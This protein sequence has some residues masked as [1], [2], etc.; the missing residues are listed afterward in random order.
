MSENP[1]PVK[2]QFTKTQMILAGLLGVVFII[3]EIFIIISLSRNNDTQ[4]IFEQS[5]SQVTALADLQTQILHLQIETR[6]LMANQ[7][8]P[9]FSQ[10]DAQLA[11][12][13]ESLAKAD[14]L[15]GNDEA[16]A[17][18]LGQVRLNLAE[19]EVI[20]GELKNNPTISQF[21]SAD[22][23]LTNQLNEAE[24]DYITPEY[25]RI[26]ANFNQNINEALQVRQFSQA[27]LLG[28]SLFIFFLVV[29]LLLSFDRVIRTEFA[30][31]FQVVGSLESAV[32]LKTRDL[33]L[34]VEVGH[35]LTQ[36][37][38]LDILLNEAVNLIRT[39]FNLYH[40]QIYLIDGATQQLVLKA[41]T[42]P[43]GAELLRR[44]H[45]LP[46]DFTS[47]NGTAAVNKEPIVVGNTQSNP[48]F[49]PNPLLPAT[50]SESAIPL[51]IGNQVLGVLDLQSEQLN[52]FSP[53]NLP[54]FE[55]VANQLAIAI[56]NANL[57]ST[58]QQ[59][60]AELE[61]LTQR[62]VAENWANFMNAVDRPEQ[63][64]YVYERGQLR[65]T[66]S[67]FIPQPEENLLTTAITLGNQPIGKIELV[68][69]TDQSWT[70]EQIEFANI[71]AQQI[72]QQLENLRLLAEARQYRSQAE[73]AV[74]QLTREGWATYASQHNT[75]GYLY[76]GQQ[77]QEISDSSRPEQPHHPLSI[78]GE[79]I[80]Y[81]T[82]TANES[83]NTEDNELIVR[84]I[85]ERLS[86]HIENLRL[87]Q[88][89]TQALTNA[90]QRSAELALINRIVSTVGSSLDLAQSLQ[91]VTDELAILTGA[92]RSGIAL[93][94]PTGSYLTVVAEHHAPNTPTGLGA[95]IPI[96]GNFTT[97]YVMKHRKTLVI[98]DVQND[99]RTEPIHQLMRTH[100][101]Y[102]L[103][104]IPMIS[105][106][107]VIGTAGIDILRPN[108]EV[109]P[110]Q[111]K[112]AETI[113]YQAT[114]AIENTR[115]FEQ[116]QQTLA[117]TEALYQSGRALLLANDIERALETA[118]E[119][120]VAALQADRVTV[121]TFDL[122]KET[123]NQFVMVGPG[124][125]Q[126]V[127]V[128]FSELWDGLSGWVLRHRQTALSSKDSPDP[129]ESPQVQQRRAETNCGSILVVP[130][131]YQNQILGTITAINRPEQPNFTQE[132][133]NLLE[134]LASQTAIVLDN[135]I[136]FNQ[137]QQRARQLE[138]LALIE[139]ALSQ[140][141]NETE[142]VAAIVHHFNQT[143]LAISTLSYARYDQDVIQFFQMVSLWIRGEFLPKIPFEFRKI[144]V[145]ELPISAH[146]MA[147][148]TELYTLPNINDPEV[149]PDL[150]QQGEQ[151]G[152]Q[153][154]MVM[155]LISGGRLQG[156]FSL[157]W[158]QPHSLSED[159]R[160]LL[161]QLLEPLSARAASQRAYLIQQEALAESQ[162][163]YQV[164]AGLNAAFN[165]D[166]ILQ[167]AVT[168]GRPI[169]AVLT[170]IE[171]DPAGA[172]LWFNTVSS[173]Q[174]PAGQGFAVPVGWRVPAKDVPNAD[175]WLDHPTELFIINNIAE[176]SRL[177]DL[178]RQ[179]Y[180]NAGS[181][182]WLV[183][184]LTQSGRWLGFISMTWERP[185]LF[186]ESDQRVYRALSEQTT[187]VLNQWLLLEETN[188]QAHRLENLSAIEEALSRAR[189]EEEILEALGLYA[190][191][192]ALGQAKSDNELLAALALFESPERQ[193]T[194]HYF[195]EVEV[196]F[197]PG[198]A[199]SVAHWRA[200]EVAPDDPFYR[201]PFAISDHPA[202]ELALSRPEHPLFIEN[203]ATDRQ[204]SNS[205]QEIAQTMAI[206]AICIV[207][208]RSAGRW[209]GFVSYT[210]VSPHPFSRD[211]QFVITRLQ[212]SLSAVV[213]SR[214]AYLAQQNALAESQ[215]LY[216]VSSRLNEAQTLEE[217]LL[218]AVS[219][220]IPAGANR[221]TLWTLELDEQGQP[222]SQTLAAMWG[223]N[224]N[225]QSTSGQSQIQF[226]VNR[227]PL[228]QYWLNS[229]DEPL[230]IANLTN[231]PRLDE[232][233]RQI[234]L[235]LKV[236]ATVYMPLRLGQRWVGLINIR[237]PQPTS[238]GDSD[239]KLYRSLATQAAAVVES[240]LLFRKTQERATQL[241]TLAH[242]QT[243]LSQVR[244]E[245]E[246]T[247]I[248]AQVISNDP[249]WT[250]SLGYL[251]VD[252]QNE[253]VTLTS[254]AAWVD[255]NFAS[256]GPTL[257]QPF[258]LRHIPI[259]R[260]WIEHP[261]QIV[262]FE[263]VMKD[264]RCD[265]ASRQ[266]CQMLGIRTIVAMPLFVGGRWQGLINWV[267]PNPTTF[268]EEQR[269]I[270]P[271]LI[272]PVGAIVT[273]RRALLAEEETRQQTERLYEASRKINE[274]GNDLQILIAALPE[275]VPIPQVN[276]LVLVS[277]EYDPAGNVEGMT[278][279]AN[280]YNG[281]GSLPSPI[282]THYPYT[283]FQTISF[284][285][286]VDT[287]IINDPKTD[288]RFDAVT[289]QLFQHLKI[290]SMVI[291]PLWA[292]NHQ[293][294]AIMLE[295]ETPTTFPENEIR[296]YRNLADQL[297][298]A[299]DNL[300]L[301]QKTQEQLQETRSLQTL[302]QTLAATLQVNDVF[303]LFFQACQ[304]VIGFEYAQLALVNKK[305]QWVTAVAARNITPESLAQASHPLDSKDIM[306][307][308]VRTGNTEII[309]GW[310][311]RFDKAHFEAAGHG[312]WVRVFT[313]IT[314]RQ[315]NIGLV[316]AGFKKGSRQRIQDSQVRLLR[317]FIDQ[318]ALALDNAQQY[319]ASQERARREQILREVTTK[320]RN[321]T[322][323]DVI[324]QTAVREIG[325]ALGR[326]VFAYIDQPASPTER[327]QN[328]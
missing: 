134:A 58:T 127:H 241:A 226:N 319:A 4:I 146:W 295:T 324:L 26:S 302:S 154:A 117:R 41:G 147:T 78:R 143:H 24:H 190:I 276:R 250:L 213:A 157:H 182:A 169:S 280:W 96:E 139:A 177:D 74:R 62:M 97:Q 13:K 199:Y 118:A 323:V 105:G 205:E 266:F 195:E 164:T 80:G 5:S 56:E 18:T 158:E 152:W 320:V 29:I 160:F 328:E 192:D 228:A 82:L 234:L 273:T 72:A 115:L 144:G 248:L 299:I 230:L 81:L 93:L 129:R 311:Q 179:V 185:H 103:I 313:P 243:E 256:E 237:W 133:V 48:H 53:E 191:E 108:Q 60:K 68:T 65:P 6:R 325:Q 130:L 300:R 219:P 296:A 38:N 233:S 175:H 9:T 120:V 306:A 66:P 123:V 215:T 265:E 122:A 240:R 307:D 274:S 220:A 84:A 45:Q 292:A 42:G 285:K 188:A 87:S 275:A 83:S 125:S 57:F 106:N 272:E 50:R 224:P 289:L 43:A 170:L 44:N 229:P 277:F 198:Y 34:A 301:F 286:T 99:P 304:D 140:A 166:E 290:S 165:P 232:E 180:L 270:L 109:N 291:I 212:E 186:N 110:T 52:G 159:E 244:N 8:A 178:S 200:G 73:R 100:G 172:P 288:S 208:L 20:L 196:Q 39:R 111:L 312:N 163:L 95:I 279:T 64:G 239:Y 138:Q 135:R 247:K 32:A 54:A 91:I 142:L 79:A 267:H 231:D 303:E 327:G 255:G 85:S 268:T 23:R 156:A 206:A 63:I 326:K 89:T 71:V 128:P 47:L 225:Q 221:A 214:R 121:I 70:D 258:D 150:R 197:R 19:Y 40:T 49:R 124:R 269:F 287:V 201:K 297:A 194:L 316:E 148:P 318:M 86:D 193:I 35:S 261:N 31:T 264:P 36:V 298:I 189:D 262:F 132:D 141:T 153:A 183:L 254:K 204:L 294:G 7:T 12:T 30:K 101:V 171:N 217:T 246:I 15:T 253:P 251:D 284:I 223:Q 218:A 151:Q 51:L 112:L 137:T 3:A 92:G 252:E 75:T 271:R 202:L 207:P 37:R 98:A 187:V 317:A 293:L 321:S 17:T 114:T 126:V 173:W 1:P 61:Q 209:Q 104:I 210:W 67:L 107:R 27:V 281:T 181:Q 174:G 283:V 211:E 145:R 136:L 14:P 203:I 119:N 305:T 131:L 25:N 21:R 238:F 94:D 33:T 59:S 77:V 10:I 46:I 149:A 76:D 222:T 308:V 55:T 245:I 309:S 236:Q 315:E 88:Q 260:L 282:G 168:I 113:V 90:E 22:A 184:P 227:F 161:Q 162:K 242:I 216:D 235:S 102:T 249:S 116:T 310:D 322:N 259:S 155:P 263:D 176:D 69:E 28:A 2:R 16:L 167:V 257:N 314:L 11:R 278:V